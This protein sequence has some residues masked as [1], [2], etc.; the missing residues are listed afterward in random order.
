[1]TSPYN[2]VTDALPHVISIGLT[3]E[4]KELITWGWVG[5]LLLGVQLGRPTELKGMIH[6]VSGETVTHTHP[7][8]EP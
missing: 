3:N 1:M 4:R 6:E 5:V 2:I 8:P 7:T